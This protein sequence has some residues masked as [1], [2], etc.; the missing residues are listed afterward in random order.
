MAKVRAH[1]G[2]H[3]DGAPPAAVL[4]LLLKLESCFY[5]EEIKAFAAS[6]LTIFAPSCSSLPAAAERPRT[7][8]FREMPL[9]AVAVFVGCKYDRSYLVD[10][11]LKLILRIEHLPM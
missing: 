2:P 6:H 11:E 3:A 8:W 1:E 9:T 7:T 5:S 10:I 4:A